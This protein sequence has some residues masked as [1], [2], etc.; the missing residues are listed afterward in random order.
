MAKSSRKSA[1]TKSTPTDQPVRTAYFNR[2]LSWLAFNRRVLEQ[3][4]SDRHPLLE[5]VMFLSIVSSNLDEFFEIRVA[6]L[7]QQVDSGISETSIDGLSPQEQL[8]RI[9][10]IATSLVSDQCDCWQQQVVPALA[11]ENIL[12]RSTKDLTR[13]E[14]S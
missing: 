5:R 8:R 3:A 1:S 14:L 9:H 2:E 11:K 6:G 10:A 12:I 4:Q 7:M 13:S